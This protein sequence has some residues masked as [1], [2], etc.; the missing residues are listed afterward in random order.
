[1]QDNNQRTNI[2]LDSK[3]M[4]VCMA[5]I[6]YSEDIAK[7]ANLH[8]LLFIFCIFILNRISS[9]HQS[10]LEITKGAIQKRRVVKKNCY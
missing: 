3:A 1:M 5:G 10:E 8:M 7:E 9:N 6:D 4:I 2:F